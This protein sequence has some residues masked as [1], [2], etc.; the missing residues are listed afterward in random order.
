MHYYPFPT[1][2]QSNSVSPIIEK[3]STHPTNLLYPLHR[4]SFRHYS[5]SNDNPSEFVPEKKYINADTDKLDIIKE[6]ENKAGIYRWTNLNDGKSY[7]GSGTNLSKRFRDYFSIRN[8]ER[9]IKNNKSFIYRSLLKYGYSN[10]SLEIL[11]YC[12]AFLVISREQYYLDLFKPEYNILK[13]AGSSQGLKHTDETKAKMREKALTFERVELLKTHNTNPES[14][15]HLKRVHTDLEIQA[16]RL[17][18]IRSIRAHQVSV[19]DT[20]TNE[21]SVYPSLRE[22]AKAIKVGKSSINQAFTRLPEGESTVLIQKKRYPR[23][24]PGGPTAGALRPDN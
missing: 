21:T 18:R 24:R 16:K 14:I 8:L 1:I 12:P 15:A 9:Q 22:A 7:I 5:T 11:E 13:I 3:F 19:L 20:V 10:F 4:I 2:S 17:E 6:N 23:R